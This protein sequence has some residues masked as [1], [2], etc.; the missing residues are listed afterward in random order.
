MAAGDPP[1]ARK[2]WRIE[3][4]PLDA[5][6]SAA[7]PPAVVIEI[8]NCGIATSGDTFQR[9]EINGRRYS[10]ILDMRTAQPLTDHALVTVIGPDCFTASLS[11]CLCILGPVEGAQL[12]EKW[13]VVARWQAQPAAAV[14]IKETPGWAKW[15]VP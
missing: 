2:G 4:A 1:P 12:A 8:A 10:H 6:G 11:T 7:K 15:T 5:E 9:L 13:K 3:V 14:E